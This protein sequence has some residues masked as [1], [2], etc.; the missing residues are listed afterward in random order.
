MY[1]MRPLVLGAGDALRILLLRGNA[2]IV[3]ELV[4]EANARRLQAQYDASTDAQCERELEAAKGRADTE[5]RRNDTVAAG[6]RRFTRR[7]Q[8]RP[9]RRD[10]YPATPRRRRLDGRGLLLASFVIR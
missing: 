3:H 5:R 8:L 9:R 2:A 7:R 6:P 10:V 4:V 1:A